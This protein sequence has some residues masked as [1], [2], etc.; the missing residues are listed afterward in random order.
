MPP[1]VI[2][3]AD[4]DPIRDDGIQ[5]AQKLGKAGVRVHH[6]NIPG[7]IHA[8]MQLI[9]TFPLQTEQAY[10]W[11]GDHMKKLWSSQQG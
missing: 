5:Y 10:H 4:C 2:V 9:E 3:T 7:V 11:L 8:F 1:A 6:K